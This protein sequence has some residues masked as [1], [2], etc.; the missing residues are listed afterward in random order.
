MLKE[1]ERT[2]KNRD[3]LINFG[4]YISVLRKMQGMSQEAL[5]E[6]AGISRS[7]LSAVE[8]PGLVKTFTVDVLLKLAD[9]LGVPPEELL[10][11]AGR[12]YQFK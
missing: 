9:A 4:I 6:K 3:I 10:E 12:D 5:A 1:N 2:L 7:L 8:A 11:A